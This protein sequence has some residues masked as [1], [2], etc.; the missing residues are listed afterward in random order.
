VAIDVIGVI[1]PGY[2]VNDGW[3]RELAARNGGS[4]AVIP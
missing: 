2:P 4:Y 1:A 3:L